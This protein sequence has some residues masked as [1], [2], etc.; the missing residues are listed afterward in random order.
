MNKRKSNN[1]AGNPSS[2][3]PPVRTTEAARELGSKRQTGP[4]YGKTLVQVQVQLF[5][6][7]RERF[8]EGT[9]LSALVRELLEKHLQELGR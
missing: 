5:E 4:R 2:L 6:G 9:N 7:Q 3:K 1:P 8:P